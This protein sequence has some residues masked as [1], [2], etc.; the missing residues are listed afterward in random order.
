MANA[1]QAFCKTG[2]N[3]WKN[4]LEV[5]NK[6]DKCATHRA[7]QEHYCNKNCEPVTMKL[8]TAYEKECCEHRENLIVQLRALRFL[9]RQGLPIF[10]GKDKANSNLIQQL[11]LLSESGVCA[12]KRALQENVHLSAEITGELCDL[13]GSYLQRALL[14]RIKKESAISEYSVMADGTRDISGVEQLCVTIRTVNKMLEA[15]ED[16]FG[17]YS[18]AGNRPDAETISKCILD[19]ITRMAFPLNKLH[20]QG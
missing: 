10:R 20:G 2:V 12:A 19:V 11:A 15:T 18:L 4:A 3:N 9:L 17:M 14:N 16:V 8:L 13:F 6:H 1:D 7:A 5:C